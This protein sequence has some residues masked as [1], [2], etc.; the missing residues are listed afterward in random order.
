MHE[1]VE[2]LEQAVMVE[3]QDSIDT[4]VAQAEKA[5]ELIAEMRLTIAGADSDD[6]SSSE[7]SASASDEDS[8]EA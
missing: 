5:S 1:N 4:I 8:D 7:D 6:G 2:R 3:I